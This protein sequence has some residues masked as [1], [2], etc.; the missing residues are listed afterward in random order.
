MN[1]IFQEYSFEKDQGK[2]NPFVI[3]ELFEK[4]KRNGK[5]CEMLEKIVRKIVELKKTN[6]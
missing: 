3:K 4:A 6:G 5:H 1:E 2:K